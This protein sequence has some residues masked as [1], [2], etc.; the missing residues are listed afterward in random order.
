MHPMERL[1]HLARA[2]PL[3]HAVLARESASA[4]AA[5]GDDRAGLLLA[6]RR[7]LERHGTSGPLWWLCARMLGADD[8]G[9]E[10]WRCV[11]EIDADP[12][13]AQ[14]GRE[15]PEHATVVVLGWAEVAV[16][17]LARRGDVRVLAVD[18]L[19]EGVEVVRWLCRCGV[20]AVDVPESGV[21]AA[22]A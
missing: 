3:E 4:L 20:D 5:L 1:R 17:G 11:G 10:A 7:L 15:L 2:G 14:L 6:S 21:G 22:V 9:A 8:P 18:A 19:G 13:P 12:T 16:A